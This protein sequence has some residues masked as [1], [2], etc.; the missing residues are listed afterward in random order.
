[1]TAEMLDRPEKMREKGKYQNVEFRLGEIENLPAADNSVDVI[2][3]NCVITFPTINRGFCRSFQGVEARR[4]A[5]GLGYRGIEETAGAYQ[6]VQ[7]T[8]IS[9]A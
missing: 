4:Q 9:A 6:G 8:L 2:I 3:S 1:M 5:D 7:L